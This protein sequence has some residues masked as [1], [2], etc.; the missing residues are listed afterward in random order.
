MT[1]A[2]IPE[3]ILLC[4]FGHTRAGPVLNDGRH[5]ARQKEEEEAIKPD[6]KKEVS[7][8]EKAMKNLWLLGERE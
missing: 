4:S 8:F 3:I 7:S 2:W 5:R 6:F 1:Q